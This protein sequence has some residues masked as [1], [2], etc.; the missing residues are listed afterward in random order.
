[1]NKKLKITLK[2]VDNVAFKYLDTENY[3]EKNLK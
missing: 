3:L 1:M 2:V